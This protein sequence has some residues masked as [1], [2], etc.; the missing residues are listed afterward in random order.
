M[1]ALLW[2][3]QVLLALHTAA[4]AVWKFFNPVQTVPSLQLIP[5]G[6][7]QGLGVFELFLG[8]ALVLPA[9]Y[10]PAALL[11]PLA[12]ICIAAVMLL[13]CALHL[14]SGDPNHGQ[15]IYWLVVA[16]VCAFVAY[17]RLALKPL[18]SKNA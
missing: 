18:Q 7:W 16:S 3:L 9:L 17:G 15:L 2:V 8:L 10:R 1:N 13:Y 11:A 5:N 6:V 14:Y 12:A 4:G